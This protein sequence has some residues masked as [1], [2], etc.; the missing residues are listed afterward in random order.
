MEP[1]AKSSWH[2]SVAWH[3]LGCFLLFTLPP[4][5]FA[6][7]N[8]ATPYTFTTFA[9]IA[10]VAG[11][12]NGT[13]SF[14]R[15]ANPTGMAI[16]HAGNLYISDTGNLT[17]R[18]VTPTGTVTTLAGLVGGRGSADGTNSGALFSYPEG[19]AVDSAGTLYVGEWQ[20]STIRKVTPVFQ[21]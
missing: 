18:K 4:A 13:G 16:D 12:N 19:I 11:S 2:T 6:Q 10:G 21:Q 17:I 9:G 5:I 3:L 8:Y 1:S 7:A 14:A 15:F 20:Y